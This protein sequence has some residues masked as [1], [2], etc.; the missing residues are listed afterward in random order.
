VKDNLKQCL[1]NKGE[2]LLHALTSS[3]LD[4]ILVLAAAT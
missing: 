2:G 1:E 4:V 3:R